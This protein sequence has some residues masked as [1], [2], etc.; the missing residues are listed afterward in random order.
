M[1]DG[2]RKVS[3]GSRFYISQG[4][5]VHFSLLSLSTPAITLLSSTRGPPPLNLQIIRHT[6]Y[7]NEDIKGIFLLNS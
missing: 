2:G 6:S 4:S 1:M 7:G 5:F 3:R